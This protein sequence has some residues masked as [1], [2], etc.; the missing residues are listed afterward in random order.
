MMDILSNIA[1]GLADLGYGIASSAAYDFLKA[2]FSGRSEVTGAE[3]QQ[4][5]RDFL[6]IK[7]V[8]ARAATVMQLLASK[9]FLQVTG[10]NL[11]ANDKL[12]FGALS[13]ATFTLGNNTRTSTDKT[14]IEAIGNAAITGSGAGIV[15]NPDGSISFYVGGKK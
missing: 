3:L 11:H 5:V 14:A 6:I 7:G 8:H 2:R 1:S 12:S 10:S 13:G 9:G 4:A 15:Q